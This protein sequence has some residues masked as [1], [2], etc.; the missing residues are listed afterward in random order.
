MAFTV[1]Y[2]FY[3]TV[4]Y[5]WLKKL[6]KG[7]K[8]MTKTVNKYSL[9]Q[10]HQLIDLNKENTNFAL[11][12]DV[13]SKKGD[14][15]IDAEFEALV[16]TQEQLDALPSLNSLVM[17]KTTNRIGGNIT[18]EDDTYQNHF[19]V[20]RADKPVDVDVHIDL[21][22]IPPKP[23]Q[24]TKEPFTVQ[25]DAPVKE[26]ESSSVAAHV[27]PFYRQYWFWLGVVVVSLAVAYF[28]LYRYKPEFLPGF[29]R[30]NNT[31]ATDMVITH[32]TDELLKPQAITVPLETE[33]SPSI[34]TESVPIPSTA[35]AVKKKKVV[36]Q[37]KMHDLY[38]QLNDIA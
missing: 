31:K 9:N 23:K 8:R 24:P 2:C 29:L 37:T 20:L 21:R 36:T 13:V 12:F 10:R 5:K 6:K 30:P 14:E 1:I 3:G 26:K 27:K 4:R 32:S 11:T 18:S 15:P 7:L 22:K 19:L 35:P 17:K 16:I 25:D 38:E 28:Y 34:T 33:V